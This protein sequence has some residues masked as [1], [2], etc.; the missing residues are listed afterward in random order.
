MHAL[1]DGD[2]VHQRY[3]TWRENAG[4][5]LVTQRPKPITGPV[6]VTIAA[7]RPDRR[8]RD[9]D[10][11]P[12]AILDLMVA[13]LLIDDNSQVTKITTGWDSA[14]PAGVVRVTVE[15]AMVMASAEA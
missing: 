4:W 6:S 8:G 1:H 3:A 2:P 5:K 12:K 13:H 9:V 15:C 10:Y 14:V 7:G 11:L